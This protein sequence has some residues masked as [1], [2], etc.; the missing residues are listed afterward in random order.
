[1]VRTLAV[2]SS[3]SKPSPRV[4]P[5]TSSPPSIA[6]RARQAVDLGFGRKGKRRVGVK[7]EEPAHAADEF[8]DLFVGKNIAE[9]QH[10]H[11][12]AHLGEF[13]D[14]RRADPAARRIRAHELREPRLDR[15]IARAQRVIF[16][17]GH[18][19][20]VLLVVARIMCRDLGGQPLQ[21]GLRLGW[22]KRVGRDRGGG[23]RCH[24]KRSFRNGRAAGQCPRIGA[25]FGCLSICR[26][27]QVTPKRGMSPFISPSFNGLVYR[28]P[29][30]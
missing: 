13:R 7:A 1:M 26:A 29:G 11:G 22:A 23:F 4:A 2:T 24:A 18:G 10:R 5:L 17:V 8:R 25:T 27:A 3:P 20:R 19:R 6:Q 16:G 9:R 12:V 30:A 28:D 21:L 14:R 15:R